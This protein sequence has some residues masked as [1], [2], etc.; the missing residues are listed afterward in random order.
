MVKPLGCDGPY[1]KNALL[2]AHKEIF[3]TLIAL[4]VAGN[5]Q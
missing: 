2:R 5:W 1:L 3:D 4:N